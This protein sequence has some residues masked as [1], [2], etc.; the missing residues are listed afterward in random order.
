M[1]DNPAPQPDNPPVTTPDIPPPVT[2]KPEPSTTPT[3]PTTPPPPNPPTTNPPHAG[4][5]MWS[6]FQ[7]ILTFISLAFFA[8]ALHVLW[9]LF[10]NHW[11]PID[12]NEYI[13]RV[14]SY[15]INGSISTL[16]VS[17]PLFIFL[18]ITTNK[19]YTQQPELKKSRS[20]KTLNYLILIITFIILIVR[21]ISAINTA[22][23]DTF[24]INFGLNLLITFLV[25]GSIFTY[26][27]YEVK[28]EKQTAPISKYIVGSIIISL[29]AIAT[30][31]AGLSV[32]AEVKQVEQTKKIEQENKRNAVS[33]KPSPIKTKSPSVSWKTYTNIEYSFTFD[34]P[35]EQN[36]KE[37]E[38][39][40]ITLGG[41]DINNP[42]YAPLA[43]SIIQNSENLTIRKWFAGYYPKDNVTANLFEDIS[44]NNNPAVKFK[45]ETGIYSYYIQ[46]DSI[47]ISISP[48]DTQITPDTQNN[49]NSSIL[50][51]FQFTN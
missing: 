50:S 30:F 40:R 34:Y 27:L 8:G 28:I 48:I 43:I 1:V 23:N 39:G 17:T 21:T 18:F 35:P 4:E 14:S 22:L 44:I 47:I 9:S 13:G 42:I 26:Y 32:R 20:K 29:I 16:L 46:G 33:P 6:A 36:I 25:N 11:L 51:T 24:T 41:Q 19:R 2:P 31:I 5:S 7:N 38:S 12:G 3:P 49:A 10:V 15:I 45:K 37:L